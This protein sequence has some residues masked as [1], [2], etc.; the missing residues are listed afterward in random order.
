MDMSDPYQHEEYWCFSK[1]PVPDFLQG[2][3]QGRVLLREVGELVHHYNLRR[4]AGGGGQKGQRP[5]PRLE[6]HAPTAHHV[7]GRQL[8]ARDV[9]R[10]QLEL[11]RERLPGGG[12]EDV[13]HRRRGTAP[14]ELVHEA[15]L[16]DPPPPPHGDESTAARMPHPVQLGRQGRHVTAPADA[17]AHLLT[18]NLLTTTILTFMKHLPM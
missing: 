2:R 11:A 6:G 15:R 8:R 10:E 14:Q 17:V 13:R 16:P 9:L 18:L 12:K 5:V 7:R 3:L 4:S 1:V